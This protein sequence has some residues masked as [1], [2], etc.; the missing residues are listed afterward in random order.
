MTCSLAAV[1]RPAKPSFQHFGTPSV[2]IMS[3][4]TSARYLQID[5]DGG[6]ILQL[7][8]V[9]PCNPGTPWPWV[10]PRKKVCNNVFYS[11][12][13]RVV[14]LPPRLCM[15]AILERFNSRIGILFTSD[16]DQVKRSGPQNSPPPATAHQLNNQISANKGSARC[17]ISILQGMT[18]THDCPPFDYTCAAVPTLSRKL[19]QPMD[20]GL[21]SE[22]FDRC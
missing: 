2:R 15:E 12:C 17:I 13:Y 3:H 22:I 16:E 5:C 7:G 14:D 4:R 11:S 9:T 1:H 19:Y 6:G 10:Q 18:R 21:C 20:T 8:T